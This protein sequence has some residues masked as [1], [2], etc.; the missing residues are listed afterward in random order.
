MREGGVCGALPNE[1]EAGRTAATVLCQ[2]PQ[3]GSVLVI[4]SGLA[5]CSR[6]L[7]LRKSNT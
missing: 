5:L 2:H 7:M 1:E 6:L 4:G 3:A